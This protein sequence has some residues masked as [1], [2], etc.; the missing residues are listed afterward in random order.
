MSQDI[1]AVSYCIGLSVADSLLQQD[2]GGIDPTALA[3]AI[4]DVF[5]GKTMKYSPEQA[6]EIIQSYVQEITTSKFEVY[7]V[8]GTEFLTENAKKEGVTTTDSGLQYEV[9]ELGTGAKPLSTDTVNVHYHGT[10]IDG[11]VF[12]SSV[13]RGIPATFGVHQVIKGWT[14]ALQLMPVG[15]KYRLYIP[16]D[17]AYGAHPHPGGAIKPFMTL[18]F[19]VE[20]LGIENN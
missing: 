12:D 13:T 20:L 14:E 19:D 16:E 2:L 17:L 15:S 3:E 10:L 9:I 8:E 7:K 1:Q 11:T 18:I 6:N 5:Q 4:S